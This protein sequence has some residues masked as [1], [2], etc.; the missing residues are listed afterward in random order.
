MERDVPPPSPV[1]F[2]FEERTPLHLHSVLD[3]TRVIICV[4]LFLAKINKLCLDGI[5]AGHGGPYDRGSTA[6]T[7]KMGTNYRGPRRCKS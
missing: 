5:V 6:I 3:W 7:L 2:Q 4:S 1:C